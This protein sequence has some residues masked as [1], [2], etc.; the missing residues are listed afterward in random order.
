[1]NLFFY[2][3]DS[4]ILET[5]N[6]NSSF[7]YFWVIRIEKQICLFVCF[8]KEVM[9][10]QFCFE[11][12]WPL[13]TFMYIHWLIL[14]SNIDFNPAIK[15]F[16]VFYDCSRKAEAIPSSLISH[17][18]VNWAKKCSFFLLFHGQVLKPKIPAKQHNKKK[19]PR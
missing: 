1:M 8:L 16:Y 13:A 7:K 2:L 11:I 14:Y 3:D 15:F 12:Y 6:R 18:L 10:R 5:W 4:E 19:K 9:D 17:W